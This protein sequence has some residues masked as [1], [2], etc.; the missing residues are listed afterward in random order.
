MLENLP[1]GLIFNVIGAAA[2]LLG[3]YF[4]LY[5]STNGKLFVLGLLILVSGF[6]LVYHGAGL[7]L[8]WRY[9]L[10]NSSVTV[11]PL[12]PGHVIDY[13]ESFEVCRS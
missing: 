13:R 6:L 8:D 1:L 7:I 4:V 2:L 5:R 10:D 12:P 11:G 9:N 3:M